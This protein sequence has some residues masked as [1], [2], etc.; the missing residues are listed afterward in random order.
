MFRINL[1]YSNRITIMRLKIGHVTAI[2]RHILDATRKTIYSPHYSISPFLL[3]TEKK[4][5][6]FLFNSP[7]RWKLFVL[8]Y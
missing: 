3:F 8:H 7:N 5:I 2:H 6:D 4:E 1:S